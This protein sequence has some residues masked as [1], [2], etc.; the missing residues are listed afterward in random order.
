MGSEQGEGRLPGSR[1]LTG[2]PEVAS[3]VHSDLAGPA[4]GLWGI[5]AERRG[6][7][8]EQ[9]EEQ[10]SAE[11]PRT[12]RPQGHGCTLAVPLPWRASQ[13]L[14][15]VLPPSLLLNPRP[16]GRSLSRGARPWRAR[17]RPG[18][19]PTGRL[20][21]QDPRGWA[22][23]LPHPHGH[24]CR[25]ALASVRATHQQRTLIPGKARFPGGRLAAPTRFRPTSGYFASEPL[26]TRVKTGVALQCPAKCQAPA[27]P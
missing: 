16:W 22:L 26:F 24:R 17:H 21:G 19:A 25:R 3:R 10:E 11:Q 20:A 9:S 15:P 12:P 13:R 7:G 5:P 8:S 1:R 18:P 6:A 4:A 23:A 2:G 14:K 27:E